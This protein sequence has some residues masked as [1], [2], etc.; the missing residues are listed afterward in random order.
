MFSQWVVVVEIW[1]LCMS[2]QNV[3]FDNGSQISGP[4]QC[5]CSCCSPVAL[6]FITGL[7]WTWSRPK[8]TI[9]LQVFCLKTVWRC[10]VHQFCTKVRTASVR[11]YA[12][13]SVHGM[14]WLVQ[15]A[16]C[17]FN[18]SFSV[19]SLNIIMNMFNRCSTWGVG[20]WATLDGLILR[21]TVP[22][23]IQVLLLWAVGVHELTSWPY[24]SH[25]AVCQNLVPLVNIKITGKWMFIPLKMVL[26]G[27]DPYPYGRTHATSGH[28]MVPGC[29]FVDLRRS[30]YLCS[31]VVLVAEGMIPNKSICLGFFFGLQY[32]PRQWMAS[33][34]FWFQT[35]QI[36]NRSNGNFVGTMTN[37]CLTNSCPNFMGKT[38]LVTAKPCFFAGITTDELRYEKQWLGSRLWSRR[39]NLPF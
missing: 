30:W 33:L 26:I 13:F 20:T 24:D 9:H 6:V 36:Q 16:S 12:A 29:C 23:W 17:A 19:W 5:S 18:I 31:S 1:M 34:S 7:S 21:W 15:I 39:K 25:M 8:C 3:C 32:L 11:A 4:K 22:G 10:H 2:P 27:I 28:C 35:Q 14:K 37:S 38:I